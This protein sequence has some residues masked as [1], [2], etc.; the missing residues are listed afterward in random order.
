MHGRMH[1]VRMLVM[2]LLILTASKV[3]TASDLTGIGTRA[4]SM[5][6]NFRSIADDYSAMFWNPAGLAFQTGSEIGFSMTLVNQTLSYFPA[7][8]PLYQER[9]QNNPASESN[10]SLRQFSA[11]FPYTVESSIPIIAVPSI[12][13][14]R[15]QGT[16]AWGIGA[17][18]AYG[19]RA[20]YDLIGT[21]GYN[22]S[23]DFFSGEDWIDD[24]KF[25]DIH[26]TVAYRFN[27]RFA[28]GVGLSFIIADIYLQK[29]AFSP[30][31]PYLKYDISE[32]HFQNYITQLP[33]EQ[34]AAL[35]Q[36]LTEL[37]SSPR[38]HLLADTYLSGFG[39]GLGGNIGVMYKP[40]ETLSIGASLQYYSTIPLE[41]EATIYAYY[42]Y[43]QEIANVMKDSI[44]VGGQNRE[45]LSEYYKRLFQEHEL[46][47]EEYYLLSKYGTGVIDTMRNK[48]LIR[49][50]MPLPMRMGIGISYTGIPRLTLAADVSMT[51]WSAWDAFD[52]KDEDD[53]LVNTIKRDWKD[54]IRA[55]FGLEY[56]LRRIKLRGGYYTE[57]RAAIN[58]TLVPANPDINRRH[59]MSLGAEYAVD[60]FRFHLCYEHT[61]MK[62]TE[63][64]EWELL[65][66]DAAFQLDY[67]NMAGQYTSSMVNFMMGLDIL[68]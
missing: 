47:F 40:V 56:D 59:V 11:T 44:R 14:V 6:G 4:Q 5:G 20:N 35:Q 33:Q 41:G 27:E 22:D 53:Q 23:P 51:T 65:N 60:Q 43:Q 57:S 62:D 18:A 66:P 29:P 19:V 58:A 28:A 13:Y 7:P 21:S 30:M 48:D 45:G 46:G 1:Y 67:Q 42:P 49:A 61:F 50:D 37:Q 26:P 12:G 10:A 68:L 31:N 52:I 54:V 2:F 39:L 16:W 32:Q 64:S 55:G 17:W 36:A 63:F 9:S 34:Q 8:S 25:I 24:M 38:D 15:N 3:F